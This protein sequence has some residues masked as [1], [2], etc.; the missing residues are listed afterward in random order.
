MDRRLAAVADGLGVAQEI[1]RLV[2]GFADIVQAFVEADQ[3]EKIAILARGRIGPA[4]R[5]VA[6][7][8]DEQAFAARALDVAGDPVAPVAASGGK[9]GAAHGLRLRREAARQFVCVTHDITTYLDR[10]GSCKAELKAADKAGRGATGPRR[11]YAARA[12]GT[13]ASARR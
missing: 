8:L 11:R 5:S 2:K 12:A 10:M 9:I 1:A 13:A 7:Q 6:E 3:I 4:A